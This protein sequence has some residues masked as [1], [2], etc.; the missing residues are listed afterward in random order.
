VRAFVLFSLWFC[1]TPPDAMRLSFRLRRAFFFGPVDGNKY[2]ESFIPV[3]V[4]QQQLFELVI[5]LVIV[6]QLVVI[7]EIVEQQLRCASR[8]P[9][10]S[11]HP[12]QTLGATQSLTRSFT[13]TPYLTYDHMQASTPISRH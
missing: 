1:P 3:H 4:Q 9:T 5:E 10:V 11:T 7:V 13:G 6:E 12:R 2:F 8:T